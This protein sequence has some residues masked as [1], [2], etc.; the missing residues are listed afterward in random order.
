MSGNSILTSEE[1]DEIIG[2]AE[3]AKLLDIKKEEQVKTARSYD[4]PFVTDIKPGAELWYVSCKA[5]GK[6]ED[7][8]NWALLNGEVFPEGSIDSNACKET[9]IKMSVQKDWTYI[10]FVYKGICFWV[11][12]NSLDIR[13]VI[14]WAS[15]RHVYGYNEIKRTALHNAM[16]ILRPAD[17]V[18]EYKG[19]HKMASNYGLTWRTI[20]E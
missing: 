11:D 12:I 4:I 7:I 20:E 5:S 1:L 15:S 10:R 2:R 6:P 8:I 13:I 19:G 18:V 9:L 14:N 16:N 17:K 3:K